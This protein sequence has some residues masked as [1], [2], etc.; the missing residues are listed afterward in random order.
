MLL[1]LDPHRIAILRPRQVYSGNVSHEGRTRNT[2]L[3]MMKYPKLV[4]TPNSVSSMSIIEKTLRHVLAAKENWSGV[5]NLY[6]RG[7]T[8]PFD[9]GE[10]LWRAGLRAAAGTYLQG[11]IGCIP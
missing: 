1:D 8:S 3:K 11:S 4:D 5:W 9:I 6:D 7:I 2:L 10:I